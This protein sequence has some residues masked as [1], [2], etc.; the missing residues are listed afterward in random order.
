MGGGA[1]KGSL[2]LILINFAPFHLMSRQL[3]T[4]VL[5]KVTA[6]LAVE[7]ARVDVAHKYVLGEEFLVRVYWSEWM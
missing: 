2:K 5:E 4:H 6:F 7:T 1:S 3:A